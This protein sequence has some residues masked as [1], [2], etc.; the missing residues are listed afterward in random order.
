MRSLQC[1]CIGF[2]LE[3]GDDYVTIRDAVALL[4]GTIE[5]YSEDIQRRVVAAMCSSI[6]TEGDHIQVLPKAFVEV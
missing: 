3:S 5:D 2:N 6:M 4:S 1:G